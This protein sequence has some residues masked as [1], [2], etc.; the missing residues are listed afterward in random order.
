MKAHEI[1]TK[2]PVTVSPTT[3]VSDI[4]AALVRHR[5]S[6]VPVVTKD[7]DVIGMVSETD[8]VR[9]A[10]TGTERKRGWWLEIFIDANTMAREYV[11]AHGLRAQDVMARPVI[12]VPEYAELSD[13]ANLLETHRIKRLPVLRNGKLVGIVSRA[14]V[15]RSLAQIKRVEKAAA[16][17]DGTLQKAVAE[18]L[19]AASWLDA[20][21]LNI[22]VEK[23]VVQLWGF[24]SSDDQRKAARVLA[25]GVAGVIRVEDHLRVGAPWVATV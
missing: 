11:K 8:L 4:A 12:S 5:I 18:K 22:T 19:R 2:E 9:R 17:D 3:P 7:N 20:T 13:V 10:E 1:M 24:V 21:Y 14:D 15:V 25:E 23:R 6:A 16:P